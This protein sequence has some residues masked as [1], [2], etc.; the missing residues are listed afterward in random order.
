MA[1]ARALKASAPRDPSVARACPRR[2]R[3]RQGHRRGARAAAAAHEADAEAG[4]AGAL[5]ALVI[6]VTGWSDYACPWYGWTGAG[7]SG[8]GREHAHAHQQARACA[9]ARV[10][11]LQHSKQPLRPPIADRLAVASAR[12]AGLGGPPGLWGVR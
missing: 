6:A 7:R 4:A 11:A 12:R 10:C 5:P 3:Q 9:L 2:Q 1:A 8:C